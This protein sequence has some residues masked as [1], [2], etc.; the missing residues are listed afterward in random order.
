MEQ[1]RLG[2]IPKMKKKMGLTDIDPIIL[3]NY[4]ELKTAH[5]GNKR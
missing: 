3:R 5:N 2:R 1:E 4:N